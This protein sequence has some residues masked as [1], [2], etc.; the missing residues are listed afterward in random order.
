MSGNESG[1]FWMLVEGYWMICVGVIGVTP[2]G[3]GQ[4]PHG[5]CPRRCGAL[6][7][8]PLAFEKG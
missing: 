3:M 6:F 7:A 8:A 4:G 5:D 2:I 1:W